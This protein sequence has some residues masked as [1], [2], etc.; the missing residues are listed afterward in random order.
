MWLGRAAC[1]HA[2]QPRQHANNN[3]L[4]HAPRTQGSHVPACPP[5]VRALCPQL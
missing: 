3:P 1:R 4:K 5:A 2:H